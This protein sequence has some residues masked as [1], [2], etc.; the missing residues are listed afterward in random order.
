MGMISDVGFASRRPDV[1]R[2]LQRNDVYGTTQEDLTKLLDIA[3]TVPSADAAERFDPCSGAHLL[4]GLEH[5]RIYQPDPNAE[6]IWSSDPWFSRHLE[7]I[8]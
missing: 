7:L 1:Q 8:A 4:Q 5:I 6:F 3:F 2:S